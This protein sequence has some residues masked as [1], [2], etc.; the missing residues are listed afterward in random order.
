MQFKK[1]FIDPINS[2]IDTIGWSIEK[3]RTLF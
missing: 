3:R 1:S 2:V